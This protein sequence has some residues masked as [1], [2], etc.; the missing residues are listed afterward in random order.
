MKYKTIE[1]RSNNY[2]DKWECTI[3]DVD[4]DR[5]ERENIEPSAQG[6]FHYPH[7]VSDEEALQKLKECM[8]DAHKKEIEKLTQSMIKLI[9]VTLP[10]HNAF[11]KGDS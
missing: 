6:F 9:E 1:I 10:K 2:E 4:G 11:L 7:T 8:I 5:Q 3:C